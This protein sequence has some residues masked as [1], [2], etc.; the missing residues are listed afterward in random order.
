MK[1]KDQLNLPTD[2][3]YTKEH[4]WIKADADNFL[5]GISDYAQDQLGEIAFI[6]LPEVGT[7]FEANAQFGTVESVKSVNSLYMPLAGTIAAVNNELEDTPTL[8][9][10]SCYGDGWILRVTL[11]NPKDVDTLLDAAAYAATLE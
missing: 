4:I 9:N 1:T 7:H 2:C 11:D 6:E 5:V 3:H 8:S 10:A